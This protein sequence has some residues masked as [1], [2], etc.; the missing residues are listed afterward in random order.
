MKAF[1]MSD[2]VSNRIL[3]GLDCIHSH[4]TDFFPFIDVIFRLVRGGIHFD[5]HR[6]YV[7]R[8]NAGLS[9]KLLHGGKRSLF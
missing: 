3:F 9:Q 6:F 8:T 4:R 2:N 1:C 5:S 7:V